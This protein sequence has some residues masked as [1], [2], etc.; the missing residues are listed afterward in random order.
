MPPET[1]DDGWNVREDGCMAG[2]KAVPFPGRDETIWLV[3]AQWP[4]PG[5]TGRLILREYEDGSITIERGRV[6]LP[7]ADGDGDGA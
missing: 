1:F 7:Q 5:T 4:T 6:W 3:K 2:G